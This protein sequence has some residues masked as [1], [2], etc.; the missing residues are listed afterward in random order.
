MDNLT[1]QWGIYRSNLPGGVD[2]QLGLR[3]IN[4]QRPVSWLH[5]IHSI[6]PIFVNTL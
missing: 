1:N 5:C 6:Y 4:C 3:T 2:S